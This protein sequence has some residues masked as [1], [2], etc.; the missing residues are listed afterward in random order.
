MLHKV[1][2]VSPDQA[3]VETLCAGLA[4]AKVSERPA[5]LTQYPTRA[6]MRELI[7][8]SRTPVAAVVVDLR[9]RAKGLELI[10]ELREAYPELPAVA[11]DNAPSRASFN[12]ATE[13]GAWAYLVPPFDLE[14][15]ADHFRETPAPANIPQPVEGRL[16]SF[17]PVQGGNGASTV[18][19]HVADAI[20]RQLNLHTLLVDF[21]FHSG[22]VAFRLR[23]KPKFTLA[24][25][26]EWDGFSDDLWDQVACHWNHL[27]VLVAPP[28][29]RSISGEHLD[30][31]PSIFSSAMRV[32]PVVIVDLPDPIFS[33]SRHILNLS[34]N[35]YLV[36]TPELMSLHL[37][38]RKAQQIRSLGVPGE[39]L[40][41]ILNRVGSWGSLQTAHVAD[42]VGVPVVWTLDNDYA[43]L[44]EATWSGGLVPAPS[45]L[46]R[47]LR[48]FGAQ[49][50]GEAGLVREADRAV[51]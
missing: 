45:A 36:C 17:M 15:L 24:D 26:V 27:D 6:E 33:S 40:R 35:V 21:D 18:A 49:I 5:I 25:V 31:I 9:D 39:K 43:A 7:T 10:R 20:A 22:T 51:S 11:A 4:R 2:I 42:V 34:S 28:S 1:I 44:R 19:L 3:L 48:E 37:A 46:A 38:R 13:A 32:Y 47:Q 14:P 30:R 23:L 8:A 50:I 12:G 16:I 29:N 41:L